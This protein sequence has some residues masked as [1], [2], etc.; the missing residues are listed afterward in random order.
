MMMMLLVKSLLCL[1]AVAAFTA[2]L[3]TK[4]NKATTRTASAVA[5][6]AFFHHGEFDD[7]SSSHNKALQHNMKRTDP[8]ILL[9]QRAIQSFMYLLV[10]TRD[11][12]TMK[13][14]VSNDCATVPPAHLDFFF[15]KK[16]FERIWAVSKIRLRLLILFAGWRT[17]MKAGTW[18]AI[19]VQELLI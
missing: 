12:H 3:S 4:I 5:R 11:P 16:T 14:C 2:H 10:C 1:S 7:A 8:K 6:R 9:T 15:H 17:R 13:W 19:M 18:T